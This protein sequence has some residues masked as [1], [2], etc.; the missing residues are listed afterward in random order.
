MF[1]CK[2]GIGRQKESSRDPLVGL[3]RFCLL[4][5]RHFCHHAGR[6]FALDS[7]VVVARRRMVLRAWVLTTV[8]RM[9]AIVEHRHH[10]RPIMVMMRKGG[11]DEQS[12][13][14]Q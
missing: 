1:R 2:N 6:H 9:A 11:D 3:G 4:L 5:L 12:Q 8:V 10:H 13:H 7:L 14:R